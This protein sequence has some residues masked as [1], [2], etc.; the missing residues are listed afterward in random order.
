[1]CAHIDKMHALIS[2]RISLYSP[3]IQVNKGS[4]C[5]SSPAVLNT[6]SK[7][8]KKVCAHS[9]G[10]RGVRGHLSGVG[11]LLTWVPG[12]KLAVSLGGKPLY[13]LSPLDNPED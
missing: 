12:A 4:H 1:M 2:V 3:G 8:F 5:N 11:S 6:C 9:L 7:D 10:T 13:Q